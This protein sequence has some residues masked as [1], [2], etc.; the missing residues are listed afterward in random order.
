[1]SVS[2]DVKPARSNAFDST[3]SADI[4]ATKRSKHLFV[5]PVG[6]DKTLLL[7]HFSSLS[8]FSKRSLLSVIDCKLVEKSLLD[9]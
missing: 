5:L 6:F 1:M 4:A 7:N 9:G 8:R 2:L 3:A